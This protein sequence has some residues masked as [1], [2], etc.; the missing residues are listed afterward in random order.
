[1]KGKARQ[2]KARPGFVNYE[3]VQKFLKIIYKDVTFGFTTRF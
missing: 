2:G 1:M 3:E